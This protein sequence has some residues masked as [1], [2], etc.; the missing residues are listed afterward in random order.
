MWDDRSSADERETRHREPDDRSAP[1]EYADSYEAYGIDPRYDSQYNYGHEESYYGRGR[2]PPDWEAR[3]AA[4]WDHQGGRCGRCGEPVDRIEGGELHH[5][6][7]LSD[8]GS[9]ALDNLV[10]LC[11]HCH[12]MMHPNEGRMRGS[13]RSAP[14]FPDPA[15]EPSVAAIRVPEDSDLWTDV[16]RLVEL[17]EPD[18]NEEAMTPVAAPTSADLARR[19]A[20]DLDE[21]LV[22]AGHVPR[23]GSH[24]RV[25]VRPR[26]SGLRG[27]IT[28]YRPTIEVEGDGT[29]AEVGSWEGHNEACDVFTTT[30]TGRVTIRMED[31]TG[32]QIRETV[33]FDD[34]EETRTELEIPVAPPPIS[35]ETAPT[36]AAA[37][38]RELVAY[39]FLWGVLPVGLIEILA[40]EIAPWET[41]IGLLAAMLVV[42]FLLRSIAKRLGK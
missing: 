25:R 4:I 8:G 22:R 21:L 34:E 28:R 11:V 35:A 6:V 18:E 14:V 3:Q 16:A 1:S 38:G 15:A 31:G 5:V 20:A 7:H 27:R 19:A 2:Y 17:D 10:G 9:N 26:M 40:T 39:P 13:L 23:S 29:A 32:R 37:A 24:H 33:W 41:W 12:T 36:Y 30:D 42:G